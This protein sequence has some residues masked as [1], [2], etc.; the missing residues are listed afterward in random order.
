MDILGSILAYLGCLT[1]LIGALAVSLFLVVA[2]SSA[3]RS[4]VHA[5]AP[6]APGSIAIAPDPTAPKLAATA[7]P[8]QVNPVVAI[9]QSAPGFTREMPA[10][11]TPAK[12]RLSHANLRRLVQEERARRWAY[13]QDPSFE[14]RFMSYAD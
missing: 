8:V 14:T 2:P 13:Q 3:H 5:S 11:G 12:K 6:A 10:A 9:A 1:G 7:T 4:A